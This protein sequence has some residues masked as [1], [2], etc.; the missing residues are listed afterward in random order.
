VNASFCFFRSAANFGLGSAMSFSVDS[1][2]SPRPV[3]LLVSAVMAILLGFVLISPEQALGL[4]TKGGYWMILTI[5]GLWV[6]TLGRIWK[7]EISAWPQAVKNRMGGGTFVLGCWILLLVHDPFGFKILMDEAM[8]AGT[9]MSMHFEKLAIVPMRGHDIQGAFELL[10]GQLDKRPLFQ[11]FLVTLL[12]DFTGY[13]PE[14]GFVLNAGLTLIL[15][16][17]VYRLSSLWGG[18][19][20]GICGVGIL[21]SLPLL[22]QN[23]TGGGFEVLNLVMIMAV[24]L[25]GVRF[26]ERRDEASVDALVVGAVLLA[27]TRYESVLFVFPVAVLIL[28]GWWKSGRIALGWPAAVSPLLLVPYAL[29]NKVFEVRESSW[30]MASLGDFDTPFSL[31]YMPDNIAHALAFFFDTT[32]EHSNSLVIAALGFLAL[33]LGALWLVKL[34][35][36]LKSAPPFHVAWAAIALGFWAHAVLMMVF[37]WGRF[38]DPVIRRLSLPLNLFMALSIVMATAQLPGQVR[39]WWVLGGLTLV[40]FFGY[41]LP[42]MARHDYSMDYYVGQETAWRREFIKAHPEKDYLVIDPNSIEWIIHQVSATPIMRAANEPDLIHFNWRNR[43]FGEIYVFQ[44]LQIDAA[45][46][47]LLMPDEYELGPAYE[48]ES[49]WERRFTPFTLSRIS[50]V[51]AINPEATA[52][53]PTPVIPDIETMSDAE[54]EAARN[55]Y[56]KEFVEKLP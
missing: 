3:A 47:D 54:R 12:H 37:F 33:G 7:T 50:R 14:N 6:V 40:G 34:P 16:I 13:R 55:A 38:D 30:E 46:G 41:S 10:G 36:R 45:T 24:G 56:F 43:V 8:L 21:T 39:K 35:R 31:A 26:A 22:A 20:A 52:K 9:A 4:M 32:G 53:G 51:I 28:W 25:L 17:M 19:R 11:P 5:F 49:V 23:A 44:R 2:K 1:L 29:H 48:L 42:T 27:L 15:L 18:D